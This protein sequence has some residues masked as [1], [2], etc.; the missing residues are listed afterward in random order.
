LRKQKLIVNTTLLLETL[1]EASV[2]R[3]R[4]VMSNEMYT[5]R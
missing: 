5:P 1:V 3:K 4:C 2:E